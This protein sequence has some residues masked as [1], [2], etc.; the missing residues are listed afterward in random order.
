ML[1]FVDL[2]AASD[3]D[4]QDRPD[5]LRRL[6]ANGRAVMSLLDDLLDLAKLDARKIVLTPEP[7]S[8]IDLV[9]EALASLD[10][11]GRAKGLKMRVDAANEAR[12]LLVTDRFRLRQIL[13]N[14]VGNA[15]KF[16]DAG[17]VVVSLRATQALDEGYWTID[18][19]D[20][21]IGIL[22]AGQRAHLFEPFEQANAS[23]ARTYGGNG[24]GLAGLSRRVADQL[25]GTPPCCCTARQAKAPRFVSP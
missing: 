18:V 25:G 4:R 5:L 13:V 14:L 23:I 7:V 3:R 19:I 16:T 10:V 8:V 15:V 12:G 2:L 24:L 1:A 9:R 22:A 6:Q 21:G 17:S 20:T 11:D